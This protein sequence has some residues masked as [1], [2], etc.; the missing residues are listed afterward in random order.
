MTRQH[1]TSSPH[2]RPGSD[3]AGEIAEG[4]YIVKGGKVVL[5]DAAGVPV[6]E[7]H[8]NLKTGRLDPAHGLLALELS[9]CPDNC[10]GRRRGGDD[11]E[12]AA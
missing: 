7:W 4:W 3:G 2:P 9:I 11:E 8:L 5:T 1:F 12:E 6:G 10:G